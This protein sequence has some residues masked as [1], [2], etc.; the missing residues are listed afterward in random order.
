MKISEKCAPYIVAL[1]SD[2]FARP[3]AVFRQGGPA[4]G[5]CVC[6]CVRV[7]VCVCVC[8]RVRVRV[9][10]CMSVSV[11]LC[12]FV[13]VYVRFPILIHMNAACQTP[14]C[15]PHICAYMS[16][17]IH[18]KPDSRSSSSRTTVSRR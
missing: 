9:R 14:A 6:V 10:V 3:L 15:F 18:V 11:C 1:G 13:C 12:V 16:A 2:A 17:C 4:S 7:C 5:E 8:V